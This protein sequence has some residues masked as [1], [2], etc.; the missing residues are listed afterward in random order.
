MS[1]QWKGFFLCQQSAAF[2]QELSALRRGFNRIEPT[3]NGA[4]SE[5]DDDEIY[6]LKI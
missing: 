4:K 6:D 5:L 2:Q 1:K 3:N